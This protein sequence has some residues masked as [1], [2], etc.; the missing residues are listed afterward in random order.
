[1]LFDRY[2]QRMTMTI[3]GIITM[4]APAVM[5]LAISS[6]SVVICAIGLCV[7]G[8]S[9][10]FQPPVTSSVVSSFYGTEHFSLNYSIANLM[11]IPAS[12]TATIGGALLTFTGSYFAP[13]L[14]LLVFS[15]ISF[16]LNLSIRHG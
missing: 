2:G 5:L 3:D 13:F 16:G 6:H 11:M 1:M 7:T 12:F 8:L 14:L 9:Y 4:A 10:S 15:V